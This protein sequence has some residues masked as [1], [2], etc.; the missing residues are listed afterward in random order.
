MILIISTCAEPLSE[1]EFV[2]PIEEL[3]GEHATMHY[4]AVTQKDI[5]NADKIIITGT[6]LKDFAYLD[7]TFDWLNTT[8]TPVLGICAGM[9]IIAQAFGGTLEES[10]SIGV[11]N[12]TIVKENPLASGNFNAYFLHTKSATG[13]FD[14]LGKTNDTPCLIKIPGKEIYGCL[15]HPE[16]MNADLITNF[17]H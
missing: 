5:A 7:G 8:D 4:S 11:K 12:V 13:D 10:P 14:V 17:I 16:V 3:V 2:K 9:H 15:F 1:L 6:A